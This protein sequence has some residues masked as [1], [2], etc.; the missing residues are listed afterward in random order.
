[1]LAR[2]IK[3]FTHNIKSFQSL[4]EMNNY[5]NKNRPNNTVVYFRANWN[6]QC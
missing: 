1:M 3:R 4:E 6:P 5:L 2:A